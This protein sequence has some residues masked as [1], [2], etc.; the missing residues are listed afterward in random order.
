MILF[1]KN[2]Y[3]YFITLSP[4]NSVG[5]CIMFLGC[6]S[7]AFVCSSGQIL[8]PQY[9]INGLCNLNET[10]VEYSLAPT[11]DLF[12]FWGSRGQGHSRPFIWQKASTSMLKRRSPSS[13]C[14]HFVL[15]IIMY[16]VMDACLICCVRFSSSY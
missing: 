12:R 6:P 5:E 11:D 16:F 15:C 7:V 4:P 8:L 13:N 14:V 9:L 3:Y 10:F 2:Y 1:F